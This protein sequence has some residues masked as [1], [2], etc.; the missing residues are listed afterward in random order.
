VVIAA[1]AHLF[2]PEQVVNPPAAGTA[3]MWNIRIKVT[4]GGLCFFVV[5]WRF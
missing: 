3:V 4:T 1:A 2:H 5:T